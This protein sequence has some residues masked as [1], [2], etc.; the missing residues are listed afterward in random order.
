VPTI[1]RFYWWKAAINWES[2]VHIYEW[3]EPV[4]LLHR[5][6]FFS[7]ILNL[8][9]SQYTPPTLKGL[10]KFIPIFTWLN[11]YKVA[12]SQCTAFLKHY[13]LYHPLQMAGLRV[14]LF[15][16]PNDISGEKLWICT[17]Q[18]TLQLFRILILFL[19][20][21]HMLV[22]RNLWRISQLSILYIF[23]A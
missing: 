17:Y 12:F 15:H 8:L 10:L 1:T 18:F 19:S 2:K 7:K 6:E 22:G 9:T 21:L 5:A 16:F 11:S 14:K 3:N 23:S 13:I 20:A 4:N